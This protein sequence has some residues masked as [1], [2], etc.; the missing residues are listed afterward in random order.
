MNFDRMLKPKS[1]AIFGVSSKNQRHPANVVYKK[2][3]LRYPINAYAI[4]PR[5]GMLNGDRLYSSLDEI[6]EPID[7]VVI[8]ARAEYVPDLIESCIKN[9]A[10]GA[11]LVSGGFAEVG[12]QE[13]QDRVVSIAQEGDF[14]I[15]GPNC[16][17][18]FTPNVIDTLFTPLE[19]MERIETGRVAIISQSGGLMADLMQKFSAFSVGIS[20]AISI[21]NKA[22]VRETELLEY[23]SKDPNTS[24]IAFYIEGFGK[25]EG[26]EFV[27]AAQSCGKPVVVL[28]SGKTPAGMNAVS[29]HTASMAG[30]YKV[31][32]EILA[33]HGIVEA[34]NE[35]EM[36]F[37]CEAL[38]CYPRHIGKN[39]GIITLSGGHGASASDAC[40]HLGFQLPQIPPELQEKIREK[41]SPSIQNIV[42]LSNPVD[43]TGSAIDEDFVTTYEMLSDMPQFD[44]LLLLVLPYSST[45]TQDLGAKVSM[46]TR[47]RI[48]PL[49]AYTSHTDKYKIFIDGFKYN[50]VPVADTIEGAVLMLK[51]MRRYQSC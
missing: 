49:V 34:R 43:L 12:N 28:K 42:S 20:I 18:L 17:G 7:L 16:I 30:D 44:A 14:P 45:I 9:G 32:S 19:R 39:V 13:L 10:G 40:S 4:N 41:L 38:S 15:I 11:I 8:A 48:K 36:M 25:N 51:A 6:N 47:K 23:L 31:F 26:R 35:T 27:Q 22:M 21:G 24:V 46:P 29:S 33:Q 5:G 2:A 37:F 1:I 50:Q 3:R